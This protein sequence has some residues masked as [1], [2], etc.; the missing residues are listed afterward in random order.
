MARSRYPSLTER[1]SLGNIQG[2]SN[3]GV[4]E[5]ARTLDVL[6]NSL[7]QMS[8]FFMKRAEA[9]AEQEG[10]EYGAENPITEK[11]LK[12]AIATG[13]D[14]EAQLGDRNTVFGRAMRK[15][16]LAI[17]ETE[18]ELSAKKQISEV[19]VNALNNESD[20]TEV[21]KDLDAVTIEY[22]K[23]ANN[24]SPIVGKRLGASLNA[25]TSSKYHEYAV[26]K[27]NEQITL[28]RAKKLASINEELDDIPTILTK[29]VNE[30]ESEDKIGL[31]FKK[32]GAVDFLKAKYFNK[33]SKYSRSK[34][35]F[36][37]FFKKFDEQVN[38]FKT[39]YILN[40]T[41]QK[42]NHSKLSKAIR[43]NNYKNID[44]RLKGVITSM[45]NEERL[46]LFKSINTQAKEIFDAEQDQDSIN[47]AKSVNKIT[48]LKIQF[49]SFLSGDD[50]NLAKAKTILN[51]IRPYD[52]DLYAELS[53]KY[54][55]EKDNSDPDIVLSF[56]KKLS[57]GTLTYDDLINNS[58][59]LDSKDKAKYFK[60]V[61][62]LQ[63]K[64]LQRAL[65]NLTGLFNTEFEGFDPG[66]KEGLEKNNAYLKPLAQYK[67]IKAELVNE[68]AE[69]KANNRSID[70]VA[71][72]KSKFDGFQ[73]KVV[74]TIKK[75]NLIKAQKS[76]D[77]IKAI[78]GN[79]YPQLENITNTQYA[80]TFE[81]LIDNKNQLKQSLGER[82][83][84][85]LKKNLKTAIEIDQEN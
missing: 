23:L 85:V 75:N 61:Q 12:D 42:G 26:K 59:G 56:E 5:S 36:E 31:I 37:S 38:E 74:I 50:R 83:Y 44:Y 84:E 48:D 76:I 8:N 71:L 3:I 81:F 45:S 73:N 13:E 2:P 49:N 20:P 68:L 32:N 82:T 24:A 17:L 58:D 6:T 11:Q 22:T 65:T 9:E 78:V 66:M 51:Q 54:E 19:M 35:S 16:Q 43:T 47:E 15:S 1:I 40:A 80:D 79:A 34:T 67:K 70:L 69:A 28:T 60:G 55:T 14:L 63:D 72:A 41:L 33:V 64:N 4:R 53:E 30:S 77:K 46:K 7:N 27:A 10:I 21:S 39:S 25:V 57:A 52:N 18:L 62:D 29:T